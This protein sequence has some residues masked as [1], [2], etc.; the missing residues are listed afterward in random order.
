M[1]R[2]QSP[3]L[4]RVGLPSV[5]ENPKK[6]PGVKAFV[7][8]EWDIPLL[9]EAKMPDS[10]D[11]LP[12]N[13]LIDRLISWRLNTFFGLPGDGINGILEALRK[14]NES[15]RFIHRSLGKSAPFMACLYASF[16]G[17]S[18]VCVAT[19]GPG[20]VHLLWGFRSQRSITLRLWRSRASDAL[21]RLTG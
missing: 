6:Q 10:T 21:T 14:K 13:G 4:L 7:L 12:A 20:G 19:S 11:G 2:I 5:V 8:A 18:G 15:I 16:P 1:P 3:K 9:Q 17:R